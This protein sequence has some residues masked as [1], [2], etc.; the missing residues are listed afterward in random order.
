MELV[1]NSKVYGEHVFHLDDED[2]EIANSRPWWLMKTK[3]GLIAVNKR[4]GKLAYLHHEILK[5]THFSDIIYKDGD[6][7]NNR[8]S[9]LL[10]IEAQKFTEYENYIEMIVHSIKFGKHS[11][12]FDKNNYEEFRQHKWSIA[13]RRGVFY[14][15]CHSNGGISLMHQMILPNNEGTV[16]HIN[17]NGLDNRVINLRR[18]S[19]AENCRNSRA[20][21]T[22]ASGYK[23]VSFYGAYNKWRVQITKNGKNSHVGYYDKIE[24]AVL[25]YNKS[26]ERHYREFAFLNKII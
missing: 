10:I 23:G 9:N 24:D 8:K 22:N 11:V 4:G 20:P 25:A 19:K 17:H 12:L 18:A 15:V 6:R 1:I 14:C 13:K 3:G 7:L 21:I 2:A 5:G 16:D 26:A